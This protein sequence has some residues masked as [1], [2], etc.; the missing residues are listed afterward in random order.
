MSDGYI[1]LYRKTLTSDIWQ[2]PPLYFRVW[3]FLLMKANYED[4]T[5]PDG[6]T[7]K[8]GQLVTSFRSL[9]QNLAWDDPET[10]HFKAPH[11]STI[12]KILGYLSAQKMIIKKSSTLR[13][14]ITIINYDT[15]QQ[16][17][18]DS[19]TL[20]STPISTIKEYTRKERNNT[21]PLFA[22]FWNLYPKKAGK[23]SAEKAWA[24]IKMTDSLFDEILSA[25]K[26][27]IE[28]NW[29]GKDKQFI[30]HPATWLNGERWTDEI[31]G[32][33]EPVKKESQESIDERWL[34]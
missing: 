24:K 17:N 14:V 29:A 30:P 13:T 16:K 15:Y 11:H 1:R 33:K 23:K 27:Q 32:L 9:V 7:I 5:M 12:Q 10:G 21:W 19:C 31:I 2:M 4:S 28:N 20:I 25:L 22:D 6:F 3:T 8:R 34:R 18:D 26:M